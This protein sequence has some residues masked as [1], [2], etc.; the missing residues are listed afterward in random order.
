MSF[1]FLFFFFFYD[2]VGNINNC[3]ASF[4]TTKMVSLATVTT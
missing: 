1:L 4:F 2:F 3:Y